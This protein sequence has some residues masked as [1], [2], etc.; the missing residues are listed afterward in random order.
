[1]TMLRTAKG[2]LIALIILIA[3]T[4]LVAFSIG[5]NGDSMTALI[6]RIISDIAPIIPIYFLGKQI[7]EKHAY[8]AAVTLGWIVL[9]S[10]YYLS[11]VYRPSF[12]M[13]MIRF[14]GIGLIL[15]PFAIV[16]YKQ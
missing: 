13:D 6:I 5:R 11:L 14:V 9:G 8:A 1:M 12:T 3:V 15:I 7:L 16:R 2:K 10:V 4:R